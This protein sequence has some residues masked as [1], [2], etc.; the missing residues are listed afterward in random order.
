MSATACV[1]VENDIFDDN[2]RPVP[3]FWVVAALLH[4]GFV[5]MFG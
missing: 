1:V 2:T 5:D 3:L 4:S